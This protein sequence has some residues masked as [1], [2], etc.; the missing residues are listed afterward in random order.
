MRSQ[1]A[2]INVEDGSDS[3][4]DSDLESTMSDYFFSDIAEDL[5]SYMESLS[6]LS[7]SL[8]HPAT[9]HL[10][11]EDV[12]VPL[13]NE[14]STVSEPAR[15]FV[16][17]IRDRFPSLE[18]GII[19]KLGEANWQ[20]RERLRMKLASAP[21]MEAQDFV[22]DDGGSSID[23]TIVDPRLQHHQTNTIRSSISLTRTFQSVTVES[24]FSDPS[25]FD[26]MSVSVPAG[27]RVRPAESATSFATSVAEGYVQ[28]QRKV[29][30]LPE[31]HV[32]RSAFQCK[33][34]GDILTSIRHRADWK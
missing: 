13:I 19:K 27:R 16:L 14:F 26:S 8:D 25:M 12:N 24:R 18:A 2:V 31:D 5:S 28:G 17:I 23:D 9:D 20:R 4:S 6:D 10:F 15:P 3:D 11:F 22:D 34:C 21:E 29:P 33:I 32:Y 30:N 7:H 1:Y